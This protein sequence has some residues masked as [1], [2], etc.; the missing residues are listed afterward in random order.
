M[1]FFN[2]ENG[3]LFDPIHAALYQNGHLPDGPQALHDQ[4]FPQDLTD[5]HDPQLHESQFHDPH[6]AHSAHSAHGEPHT[7]DSMPGDPRGSLS[8]APPG[9]PADHGS[10]GSLQGLSMEK[11]S[12]EMTTEF[13][14]TQSPYSPALSFQGTPL[15][16]PHAL[17]PQPGAAT[18]RS[19]LGNQDA[20]FY[21]RSGKVS[22]ASPALRWKPTEEDEFRLEDPAL[23]FALPPAGPPGPQPGTAA[24]QDD[25]DE[26]LHSAIEATSR[27]SSGSTTRRPSAGAPAGASANSR[28]TSASSQRTTPRIRPRLSTEPSP[29][30]RPIDT[31][32]DEAFLK[33]NYHNLVDGTHHH[34]GLASADHIAAELRSKKTVHKLAEQERRQRMNLAIAD[35][36]AVL[37]PAPDDKTVAS[38]AA[39]V[40]RATEYIKLLR[41]RVAELERTA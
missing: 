30:A 15:L 20:L 14:L 13:D 40:E 11:H 25:L 18:P 22:K 19:A 37:G 28:R 12:V 38:K 23:G 27:A 36:A 24:G 35:L 17:A 6:A 4:S 8:A 16:S 2:D 39:T 41:S 9:Q 21:R 3:A 7:H 31:P 10:Q 5:I 26:R 1:E 34:L 29:L 33:S 32:D